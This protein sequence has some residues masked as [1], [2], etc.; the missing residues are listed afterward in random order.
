MAGAG[1]R[2][3]Q[4]ASEMMEDYWIL[5]HE[6]SQRIAG[7]VPKAAGRM[8]VFSTIYH[9]LVHGMYNAVIHGDHTSDIGLRVHIG[10]E[11]LT[12]EMVNQTIPRNDQRANMQFHT[13]FGIHV[14]GGGNTK[15]TLVQIFDH[16]TFD[17][18]QG[19][20]RGGAGQAKLILRHDLKPRPWIIRVKR[21]FLGRAIGARDMRQLCGMYH[22]YV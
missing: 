16:A 13:R 12:L 22:E 21:R 1:L 17:I 14:G 18:D 8:Y 7:R 3:N 2:K 11:T 6:L 19:Q 20:Q 15:D 4:G 9:A 10:S 5:F